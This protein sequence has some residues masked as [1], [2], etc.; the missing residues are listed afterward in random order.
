[1]TARLVTSCQIGSKTCSPDTVRLTRPS[2]SY[3]GQPRPKNAWES[4]TT[5][6]RLFAKPLSDL[7]AQAIADSQL[8]LVI[9]DTQTS[10]SQSSRK[11]PYDCHLIFCGVRDENVKRPLVRHVNSRN[12]ILRDTAYQR[13]DVSKRCFLHRWQRFQGFDRDNTDA[14]SNR[15]AQTLHVDGNVP[16]AGPRHL[17]PDRGFPGR[18]PMIPVLTPSFVAAKIRVIHEAHVG[19]ASLEGYFHDGAT[20]DM[21]K[22]VMCELHP[23]PL[24][25]GLSTSL[26]GRVSRTGRA[27]G[28][29][30]ART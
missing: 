2:S 14:R 18:A 28:G 8:K 24:A 19:C 21:P 29:R 22:F 23:L 1:M 15:A 3:S 9:P 11:W 13:R 16:R 10:L 4:T 5:P 20:S 17:Q 26:R 30:P 6:K 12:V 27:S 25:T 7:A